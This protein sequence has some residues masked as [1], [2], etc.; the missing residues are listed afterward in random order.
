MPNDIDGAELP[1]FA[2]DLATE[3]RVLGLVAGFAVAAVLLWQGLVMFGP[4]WAVSQGHG[5]RGEFVVE[6]HRCGKEC[7]HYGTF[8]SSGGDVT[9]EKV[10]LIRG[11]G[12]LGER[13]PAVHVGE[14]DPPTKV[15]AE[16][17][18]GLLFSVGLIVV[19]AFAI[20][21]TL[22]VLIEGVVLWR[23]QQ[24]AEDAWLERLRQ[25]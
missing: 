2:S 16:E 15:Y 11:G 3:L 20:V 4:A 1:S 17:S 14:D 18:N 12:A 6:L 19:G 9:F 5:V 21:A 22:G 24:S 23:R 10:N 25:A 8:T 7:D 13:I